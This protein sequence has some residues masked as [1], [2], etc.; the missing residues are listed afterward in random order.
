MKLIK[1][2]EHLQLWANIPENQELLAKKGLTKETPFIVKWKKELQPSTNEMIG[3]F[4]LA[5]MP[6][7][8]GLVVST[9]LLLWTEYRSTP[10]GKEFLDL[11]EWVPSYLG[12]PAVIATT[13]IDNIAQQKSS[14]KRAYQEIA[15]W[16]N[17]RTGRKL[18]IIFKEI[19]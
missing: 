9:G 19:K 7:C 17:S 1:E 5:P 15:T 10:I 18:N 13:Q 2:S 6:G 12:Y 11:K 8:C 14:R 3:R 4:Y 16:T